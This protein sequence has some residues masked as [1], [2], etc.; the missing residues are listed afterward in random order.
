MALCKYVACGYV[1]IM[2]YILVTRSLTRVLVA[3]MYCQVTLSDGV[4]FQ[5]VADDLGYKNPLQKS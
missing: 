3:Q 5:G 4:A 2:V 1:K